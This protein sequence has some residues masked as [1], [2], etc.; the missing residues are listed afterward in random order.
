MV[1]AKARELKAQN[2]AWRDVAKTLRQLAGLN[3][4]QY[5]RLLSAASLPIE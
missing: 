5:S 4:V 1:R 3:D 2:D